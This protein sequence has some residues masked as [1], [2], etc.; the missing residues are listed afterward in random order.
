M[1]LRQIPLQISIEPREIQNALELISTHPNQKNL[2]SAEDLGAIKKVKAF[3]KE[4]ANNNPETPITLA[5]QFALAK[6][7]LKTRDAFAFTA[8]NQALQTLKNIFGHK[9]LLALKKAFEEK[10]AETEAIYLSVF[11]ATA[12]VETK[13]TTESFK[14]SEILTQLPKTEFKQ[15]SVGETGTDEKK[16]ETKNV[17]RDIRVIPQQV[18]LEDLTPDGRLKVTFRNEIKEIILKELAAGKEFGRLSKNE[19]ALKL[20]AKPTCGVIYQLNNETGELEI[21]WV[22]KG[23][24][25]LHLNKKGDPSQIGKL[26][27]KGQFGNIK[28]LQKDDSGEW[29]SIKL[30][31]ILESDKK[32]DAEY[33]VTRRVHPVKARGRNV[34]YSPSKKRWQEE[35]IMKWLPGEDLI[36]FLNTVKKRKLPPL[37]WFEIVNNVLQAGID[38]HKLGF[39]HRDLKPDN[40]IIFATLI[41]L[42]DFGHAIQLPPGASEIYDQACGSPGYFDPEIASTNKFSQQTDVY[43]MGVTIAIILDLI[44]DFSVKGVGYVKLAKMD[45]TVFKNN[46]RIPQEMRKACLEFVKKMMGPAK[47]R[48]KTFEE[49]KKF[50]D[51]IYQKLMTV[52][53][54]KACV[55]DIDE[56]LQAN[57]ETRTRILK[58]A[59]QFAK[60]VLIGT[61]AH[62]EIDVA[63]AYRILDKFNSPPAKVIEITNNDFSDLNNSLNVCFHQTD[64]GK[65]FNFTLIT[66]KTISAENQDYLAKGNIVLCNTKPVLKADNRFD[67]MLG[68]VKPGESSASKSVAQPK[69]TFT[70]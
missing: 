58:E 70:S 54:V 39:L 43:A 13:K 1:A 45:S 67:Q 48:P 31:P 32:N 22:Y 57:R 15:V 36:D 29:F 55:I 35:I 21:Y 60:V 47:S 16:L 27:G 64:P 38:F 52:T 25:H 4:I 56:L 14:T 49:C 33:Q 53:M 42:I 34:R 63:A 62:T 28:I 7:L 19:L 37:F 44:V 68:T 6:I 59:A 2:G 23:E 61:N 51:P 8:A 26:A 17:I 10:K 18:S 65:K 3:Y 46:T 66:E 41:A 20:G 11:A 5:Q 30:K 40:F 69:V 24:K 9:R 12:Q 50:F